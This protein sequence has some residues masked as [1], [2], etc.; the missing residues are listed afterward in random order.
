MGQGLLFWQGFGWGGPPS[1]RLPPFARWASS[2]MQEAG[3]FAG[4]AG[5]SLV[6]P[7]KVGGDLWEWGRQKVGICGSGSGKEVLWVGLL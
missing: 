1:P 6:P 4:G 7:T 5:R 3:G 2:E